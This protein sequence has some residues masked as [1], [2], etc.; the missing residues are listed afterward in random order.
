MPRRL[1]LHLP[2]GFYHATLRGNHQQDIFVAEG[3]RALL[4]VIVARAL[5]AHGARLHAYCW[6]TNHLHLLVQVGGEPLG[7]LMR[8]IAS[9][10]ARAMQSKMATTGHYFERRYHATLVDVETYLKALLR[11]IHMNP[12]EAGIVSDPAHFPWSSHRAYL[13][14]RAEPSLTVDFVLAV[15]GSTRD[16]AI[17][18]YRRFMALSEAESSGEIEVGDSEGKAILGSDDF[19]SK[20]Q[21]NA[22]PVRQKQSL[23]ALLAEACAR[24]AVTREQLES[25]VRD[26]YM[27]K[28]RAWVA[29][30]ARKRGV[31]SLAAV[32]RILGRHEATLRDAIRNYPVEVE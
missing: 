24:F 17:A 11:Y 1:R 6:M 2:G 32:A 28:V 4:N 18:E 13:G 19:L 12:V 30:Q 21:Q 26:G 29:H 27:T 5:D 16:L 15:F 3:D 7:G 20:V 14:L 9:E 25:P 31:A 8:Q 22:A 10:F 23:D